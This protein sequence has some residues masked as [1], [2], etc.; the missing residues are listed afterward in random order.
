MNSSISD[1]DIL[2]SE[3]VSDE[4][5]EVTEPEPDEADELL[6]EDSDAVVLDT[7]SG[8]D[9]D[10]GAVLPSIMLDSIPDGAEL[11]A[12]VQIQADT[13]QCIQETSMVI[14]LLLGLIAGI[15]LVRGLGNFIKGV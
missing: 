11:E 14:I 15:L 2:E 10:T 4:L 6:E 13:L 7:V 12:I 3:E 8:N 9:S 5:K 1:S